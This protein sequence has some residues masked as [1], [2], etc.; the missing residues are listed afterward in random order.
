[1]DRAKQALLEHLTK[2]E[3]RLVAVL[4]EQESKE[5]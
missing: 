1:V 2:Y 4:V 5:T 3:S